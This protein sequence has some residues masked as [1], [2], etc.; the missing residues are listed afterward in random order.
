LPAPQ[1]SNAINRVLKARGLPTLDHPDVVTH[2]ASL[3]VD[4]D[5]FMELLRACEPELRRDMYE[6]MSP[7]LYFTPKPLEDYVILAKEQAA[8][9]QL[10]TL[11]AEGNLH[12][13]HDFFTVGMN[14]LQSELWVQCS[15]CQRERYFYGERRI[16]AIAE[17]RN[18]GWGWDEMEQ[19][20]LCPE[21]LEQSEV[22]YP[23]DS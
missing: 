19:K 4:H 23:L 17:C 18:Q 16:D 8:A 3:V 20:H 7:H 15:H 10:P 2:L 14:G 21:C 22:I 9:K 1:D 11:D 6:A 12:P 5:H 13:Y